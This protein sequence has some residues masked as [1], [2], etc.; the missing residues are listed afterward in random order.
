MWMK[1]ESVKHSKVREKRTSYLHTYVESRK[2]KLMKLFAGHEQRETEM[3]RADVWTQQGSRGR[4]GRRRQLGQVCTS[5]REAGSWAEAAVQ[6]GGSAQ[7]S[8]MNE[9]VRWGA[10]GVARRRRGFSAAETSATLESSY[11]PI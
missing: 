10:G 3:Q 6:R 7:E 4:P 5:V 11:S 9:R 8:V 2:M 1:L